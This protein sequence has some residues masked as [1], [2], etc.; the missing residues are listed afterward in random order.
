MVATLDIVQR[1]QILLTHS[2]VHARFGHHSMTSCCIQILGESL[3]VVDCP[4]CWWSHGRQI[5]H[6][7]LATQGSVACH[8]KGCCQEDVMS[9]LM[10][11][12]LHLLHSWTPAEKPS[13][14]NVS[15]R[16]AV[17]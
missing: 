11:H 10:K 13:E 4:V 1:T 8:G 16:F 15:V 14:H 6:Q 3:V 17:S 7:V 12:H 9:I 5:V 2:I